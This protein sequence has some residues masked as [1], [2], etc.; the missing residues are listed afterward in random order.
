[1]TNVA[2]RFPLEGPDLTQG[3]VWPKAP[4]QVNFK[5]PPGLS[6]GWHP[7]MIRTPQATSNPFE[8][9]VDLPLAVDSLSIE[10]MHDSTTLEPNRVSLQHGFFSV[11]VVGLPRN[12]DIDIVDLRMT[13][14]SATGMQRLYVECAGVR[15]ESVDFEVAD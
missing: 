1:M 15:S 13:P 6:P 14:G 3:E 8:I 5:L 12:A 2:C 4:G 11:W 7:V 9:A 10:G